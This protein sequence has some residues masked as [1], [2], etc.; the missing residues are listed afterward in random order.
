MKL[1]YKPSTSSRIGLR[2]PITE[3][4]DGEIAKTSMGY[5]NL[6][7]DIWKREENKLLRLKNNRWEEHPVQRPFFP[8]KP[9]GFILVDIIE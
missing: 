9:S 8:R 7:P 5:G 4:E 3:L 2:I 1:I 6:E